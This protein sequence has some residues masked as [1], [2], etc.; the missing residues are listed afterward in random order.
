MSM[1]SYL[2][3]VNKRRVITLKKLLTDTPL[4]DLSQ[5]STK[6]GVMDPTIGTSNQGDF[7]IKDAVTQ[8]LNS[9]FPEAFFTN[10]PSQLH[11][12]L[13]SVLQQR[14]NERLLFVAGTNLL[15]SNMDFYYQ[16]KIGP[17]DARF[18]KNRYILFGVGWWQYQP[19][20]NPYTRWLYKNVLSKH[21]LHAVR[22]SYTEQKLRES[23]IANVLNTS[24]PTLWNMTAD[25]CRSIP[26][27]RATD[28]VTTLTFY[29]KNVQY[30]KQ[31][32]D[33][34]LSNYRYV[35]V[36]IQGVR[37][38]DYLKELNYAH[39]ERLI[40]I[41]P[42]L[43]AFDSVLKQSDIEYVGTRLHAGVRALQH[44]NRT[45]ILAVDNRALEIGRDTNL[46]VIRREEVDRVADFIDSDYKTSIHLP[47]EAIAK[48]R[49]QFS[50]LTE[51]TLPTLTTTL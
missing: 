29:H 33:Q 15:S 50:H 4:N 12:Q 41:A 49:N 11:R 24:C 34:L 18:L 39:Q 35:Y 36:W 44:G 40:P 13:D 32:L 48:W 19:A 30:D 3:T 10:Y 14:D 20:T 17:L 8:H 9:L 28:V 37:D 22:D 26:T 27:S 42:S 6:I 2:Y 16:W 21:Y 23:G 7:I 43:S 38:L 31:L 46:N 51:E 47:Q 25:H 45:L 1:L 5:S